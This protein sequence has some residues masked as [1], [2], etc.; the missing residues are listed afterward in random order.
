MIR[1]NSPSKTCE[2]E[3]ASRD[4][5]KTPRRSTRTCDGATLPPPQH[6]QIPHPRAASP[7]E[8]EEMPWVHGN[9]AARVGHFDRVVGIMGDD[10]SFRHAASAQA[11]TTTHECI[12]R[13]I[14][15][16]QESSNY[17][18]ARHRGAHKHLAR[19][20]NEEEGKEEG[21]RRGEPKTDTKGRQTHQNKRDTKTQTKL[22]AISCMTCYAVMLRNDMGSTALKI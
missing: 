5:A 6:K 10:A 16:A 1:T 19:W 11:H 17:A 15:S 13:P 18:R 12:Y 8:M 2:V 20:T 22:V 14:G 7:T 3:S 4:R 9:R 21:R